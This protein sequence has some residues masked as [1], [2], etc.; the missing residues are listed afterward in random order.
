MKIPAELQKLDRWIWWLRSNGKKLP[1]DVHGEL[2]DPTDDKVWGKYRKGKANGLDLGRGFVFNGDGLGGIDLDSCIAEGVIAPWAQAIID[3]FNSYAEVSPSGT[4]VKIFARGAPDELERNKVRMGPGKKKPPQ[5]EVYVKGRYFCV[6]GDK[7]DGCP[8]KV[9]VRRVAW[10]VIVAILTSERVASVW[11]GEKTDGDTTGSGMDMSLAAALR[12]EGVSD[13]GIARALRVYRYGQVRDMR[14]KDADRQVSRII[15]KLGQSHGDAIAELNEIFALVIVGGRSSVLYQRDDEDMFMSVTSF[16]HWL[17]NRFIGTG[18]NQ[19]HLSEVWLEHPHRRQYSRVTFAPGQE[20]KKS[21]Y[22]LWRGFAVEPN[23]TGDCSLFIEHIHDNVAQGDERVFDWIMSW[24]AEIVQT[25]NQRSG[26]SLA[27]RGAVGTG[28]T[29][30]G[31]VIGSLFPRHYLLADSPD[32]VTGKF[33]AHMAS[34]MLLHAD[35][36]FFAGDPR[37]AGHLRSIVTRDTH[38]IQPKGVDVFTVPNYMRLLVTSNEDWVV[39]ARMDERRWA[40]VDISSDRQEDY[41]FFADMDRQLVEGGYGKLLSVLM[42]WNICNVREI[43]RTAGLL[44]NKIASMHGKERWWFNCLQ[45]GQISPK[46][47]VWTDPVPEDW[48]VNSFMNSLGRTARDRSTMTELGM[49]LHRM[50]PALRRNRKQRVYFFTDLKHCRKK[51]E[52]QT[53]QRIDW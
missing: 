38:P 12:A 26:T 49:F 1:V 28:K 2:V 43:P 40:I 3:L 17:A 42:S 30:I 7:V 34:L 25:P 23:T 10:E 52:K 37:H 39:P 47:K 11:R 50:V 35:E 16:R 44:E 41:K 19:R 8:W 45:R 13:K 27:I 14:D 31:S 6:T 36:A 22:N 33:N 18:R 4:G 46:H 32:L 29:K 53:Q 21:E 9:R 15:D 5:V 20:L 48:I 51:F 24:F